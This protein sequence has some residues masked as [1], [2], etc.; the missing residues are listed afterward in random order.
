P[1][2]S[3][4]YQ[5]LRDWIVSGAR[6]EKGSGEVRSV[7][8]DPP[9]HAFKKAG[10]SARL[11][12]TAHFARGDSADITPFCDFRT[13]DDAVAEGSPVGEARAVRPGA[14]GV[15]VSSR[16]N[17]LPV[18][19][20]VPAPTPPGFVSPKVPEVNYIDCE[21]F[22]RLRRLNMVPSDLAPD[23]EFLRRLY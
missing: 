3:W 22:A 7:Q 11:R 8:I 2:G 18:R 20:L 17:V 9:E 10:E 4:Q 15:V 14:P 1:K 6:W 5:A 12:V 19:V 16:G 23:A 13:N 21:V